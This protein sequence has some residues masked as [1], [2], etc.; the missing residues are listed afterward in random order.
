VNDSLL[1]G[2]PFA[3]KIE[4]IAQS[5]LS[6]TKIVIDITGENAIGANVLGALDFQ[7]KVFHTYDAALTAAQVHE[8]LPGVESGNVTFVYR[9]GGSSTSVAEKRVG[10]NRDAIS[11]WDEIIHEYGHIVSGEAG[12]GATTQA[13]A[14][15][16]FVNGRVLHAFNA[17]TAL[18]FDEGW[19]NFYSI[20]AQ[21]EGYTPN[22]DPEGFSNLNGLNYKTL[23]GTIGNVEIAVP[24]FTPGIS[25][26]EGHGEDE[27][28]TI[29]RILWD[30]YDG[31]DNSE[32]ESDLIQVDFDEIFQLL[33]DL[34]TNATLH[35]LWRALTTSGPATTFQNEQ[36]YASIFAKNGAAPDTIEMS[37]NGVPGNPIPVAASNFN[38]SFSWNMPQAAIAQND[39]NA[40]ARA[41]AFSHLLVEFFNATGQLI[42]KFKLFEFDV[43]AESV[44]VAPATNEI[45]DFLRGLSIGDYFWRPVGAF[46]IG[47]NQFT[48][49]ALAFRV[50]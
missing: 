13:T 42:G 29:T 3:Y 9:I 7:T 25:I 5:Q 10:L 8:E 49:E 1:G 37:V 28:M 19:A 47:A 22:F 41:D 4:T 44:A 50:E 39:G 27:E 2:S 17:A 40:T 20:M 26:P 45:L 14:H 15:Y 21:Q 30:L 43:S 11:D 16:L 6:N 31:I 34:N 18:A 32:N 33:D 46:R 24:F 38:A 48:G 36:I 35:D 23:S 12:F